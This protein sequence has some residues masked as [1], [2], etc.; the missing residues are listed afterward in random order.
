MALGFLMVGVICLGALAGVIALSVIC[1]GFKKS[2]T[3]ETTGW[4]KSRSY[5]R[6]VRKG[7]HFYKHYTEYKYEYSVE[8]KIYELDGSGEFKPGK[9]SGKVLIVYQKKHPR[10]A[11]IKDRGPGA[12]VFMLVGV[13]A[14]FM[15]FL[16]CGIGIIVQNIK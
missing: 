11:Y 12:Y 2:A 9:V 4:I 13:I 8:G 10:L 1:F 6:N 3:A 5:E 15:I 16:L 14:V 7:K